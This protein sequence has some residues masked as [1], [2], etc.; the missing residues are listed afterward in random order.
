MHKPDQSSKASGIPPLI[1]RNTALFA[2]TLAFT[3]A[4]MNFSFILGPL[5]VISLMGNATFAGLAVGLIGLSRFLVAYP[6]GK[7]TDTYGR[8]PGVLFGLAL[9]LA[10]TVFVG[11]S[12]SLRSIAVL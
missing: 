2:V 1:K 11:L 7:I 3:G 6:V 4:G 8:K 5:M 12:M 10:G 9:G